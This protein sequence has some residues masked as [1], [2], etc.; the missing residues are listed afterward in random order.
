MTDFNITQVI[1][2]RVLVVEDDRDEA[3]FLKTFLEQKN[4]TV[5]I[6]RDGG[7]A[8]AAFTMHQPDFVLLDLILP[9]NVSGFEVCEWMKSQADGMPI[10]MLTAIELEDSK[11]LAKRVGADDYV[12]KPYDPD[13]LLKTIHEVADKVWE[14]RHRGTDTAEKVKFECP[15]CGKHLRVQAS[16]RGRNLNCPK[17]GQSVQVPRMV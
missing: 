11:D 1:V 10:V 13:E 7:Q 6:A 15:E 17:C 3:D 5:E 12:T 2:N 8:R 4:L 16:Y 14:R 9:N